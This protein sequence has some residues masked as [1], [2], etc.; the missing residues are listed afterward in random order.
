M[1]SISSMTLPRCM[2]E[3]REHFYFAWQLCWLYTPETPSKCFLPRRTLRSWV[4][5]VLRYH[6]TS[7]ISRCHSEIHLYNVP[8]VGLFWTVRL[9][10]CPIRLVCI[11]KPPV[12]NN[13]HHNYIN[14]EVDTGILYINVSYFA[15]W[16]GTQNLKRAQLLHNNYMVVKCKMKCYWPVAV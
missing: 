4:I 2:A 8:P 7:P 5:I 16:I 12:G 3:L 15:K 10:K 9:S 14:K 6:I 1:A 11:S 13:L